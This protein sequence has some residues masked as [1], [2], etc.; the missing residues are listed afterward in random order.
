MEMDLSLL[1][2]LLERATLAPISSHE[3]GPHLQQLV[4][5]QEPGPEIRIRKQ[6]VTLKK[7]EANAAMIR[8]FILVCVLALQ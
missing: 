5:H 3:A 7:G 2:C 6:R 1:Q 4:D 8:H